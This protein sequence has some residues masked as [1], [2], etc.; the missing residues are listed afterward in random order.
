MSRLLPLFVLLCLISMMNAAAASQG[1]AQPEG[2]ETAATATPVEYASTVSNAVGPDDQFDYYVF[3][4]PDG[5]ILGG[6][7]RLSSPVKGTVIKITGPDGQLYQANTTDNT[8]PVVF[9]IPVRPVT[10]GNYYARIGFWSAEAYDHSY[11]LTFDIIDYN[12]VKATG[13]PWPLD[14]GSVTNSGRSLFEGPSGNLI[15]T[16]SLELITL[17]E[18]IQKFQYEL[19]GDEFHSLRVGPGGWIYFTFLFNETPHYI[20]ILGYNLNT[21]DAWRY[22][23]WDTEIGLNY[24]SSGSQPQWIVC[25]CTGPMA[26]GRISRGITIRC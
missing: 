26:V 4:V 22:H 17:S 25:N 15:S 20:S 5:A 19:K 24:K 7:V 16:K 21:Q 18:D 1:T 12:Q 10:A 23:S 6:Y 2:N 8:L 14:R 13:A 3:K 11:T 9:T